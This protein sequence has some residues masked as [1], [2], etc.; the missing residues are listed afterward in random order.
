M[1]LPRRSPRWL[2]ARALG[3]AALL[4]ASWPLTGLAAPSAGAGPFAEVGAFDGA[5]LG[6]TIAAWKALPLPTTGPTH[7]ARACAQGAGGLVTCRY[8]DVY[9]AYDLPQA[10][11]LYPARPA[12]RVRYQFLNGRLAA[13]S[14]RTSID[15]YNDVVSGL[16]RA[17]GKPRRT[18]VDRVAVGPGQSRARVRT[19]WARSGAQVELTDPS[20]N[21][22]RLSLRLAAAR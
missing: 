20:A 2:A 21:P 9:G 16:T 14:L 1:P 7:L 5:R 11:R 22:V 4:V 15:A 17:Y 10:H 13:I 3:A 19:T 12:W 8:A 6:M 18:R